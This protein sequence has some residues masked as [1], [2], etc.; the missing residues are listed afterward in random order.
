MNL[1]SFWL[2]SETLYILVQFYLWCN[3]FLSLYWGM[4]IRWYYMIKSRTKNKNALSIKLNHSFYTLTN[5]N[6]NFAS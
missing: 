6:Q 3:F 2:L 4:V 1:H 5:A